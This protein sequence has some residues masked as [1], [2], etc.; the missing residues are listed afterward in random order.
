MSYF[1]LDRF[2]PLNVGERISNIA[3]TAVKKG[4]RKNFR[5]DIKIGSFCKLLAGLGST[6]QTRSETEWLLTKNET[7]GTKLLA[8]GLFDP[9]TTVLRC[10]TDSQPPAIPEESARAWPPSMRVSAYMDGLARRSSAANLAR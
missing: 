10:K 7:F 8:E 1:V 3:L 4:K 2:Q 5:S 6:I 9:K